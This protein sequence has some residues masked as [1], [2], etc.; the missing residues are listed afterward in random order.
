LDKSFF[1]LGYF[2]VFVS[3]RNGTCFCQEYEHICLNL[4]GSTFLVIASL[5]RKALEHTVTLS[6]FR[7][8]VLDY[9]TK[10]KIRDIIVIYLNAE[11]CCNY[12]ILYIDSTSPAIDTWEP[13]P[14]PS[15]CLCNDVGKVR[16]FPLIDPPRLDIPDIPD[17]PDQRVSDGWKLHRPSFMEPKW[18][19]PGDGSCVSI[20]IQFR[21]Y[22]SEHERKSK[23]TSY[24]T[25]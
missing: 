11:L 16:G 18:G 12:F 1:V 10:V 6:G 25:M 2:K 14:C 5:R 23:N 9:V 19:N 15:P 21:H 24:A 3:I 20:A 8:V 4:F 7:W 22:L 17:I 13:K